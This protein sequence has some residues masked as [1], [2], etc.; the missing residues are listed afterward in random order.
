MVL[1][2]QSGRHGLIHRMT[3]L[4]YVL[5]DNQRDLLYERFVNLAE[6]QKIVSDDDLSCLAD[7]LTITRAKQQEA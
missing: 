5:T 1:G 7:K 6:R 4:G 3:Q 2:K